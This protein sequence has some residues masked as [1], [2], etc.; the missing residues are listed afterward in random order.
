MLEHPAYDAFWR[1]QAVDKILATQPLNVRHA[2]HSLWDQEDNLWR[3]RR[4]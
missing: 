1:D 4:V 3:H 2:G